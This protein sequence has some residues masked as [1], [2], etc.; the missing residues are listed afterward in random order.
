MTS[1]AT[2]VPHDDIGTELVREWVPDSEPR[3]TL[4]LVHG[5]AEHS[6]RYE[7]TG[8]LLADAGF[9]VRAFDVIGHGA[10][11]GARVDIDDWSRFLGQVESHM[12]WAREQGLPVI[13]MGQ[14]MGGLMAL[15]YTLDGRIEPDLLVLSAPALGGGAAW[16]RALAGAATRIAPTLS[17]PQSIKGE[18][19]SR[20]PEVAKA[21]FS[22]PLVHTKATTRFG[23]A[24][25]DAMDEAIARAGEMDVPTLVLHGGADSLVPPQSTA[26]LAD[27]PNYERTLYPSLRHEILNEPEGPEI[28]ADIVDWINARI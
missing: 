23:K 12:A 18:D 24:M 27:V 28:V 7:R 5:I 19:L 26:F 13:L 15:G 16:Q 10:S 3:A 4:V 9:H 1:V 17:M 14:S 11:G 8:G 6:G 21:Y 25:F 2:P 20:D 22:D